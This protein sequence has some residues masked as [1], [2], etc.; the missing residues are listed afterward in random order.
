MNREEEIQKIGRL[1]QKKLDRLKE[2]D[3]LLDN[4]WHQMGLFDNRIEVNKKEHDLEGDE[5]LV[6][7]FRTSMYSKEEGERRQNELQ[8]LTDQAQDLGLGYDD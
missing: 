3:V 4:S 2:L 5:Q 8:K 1:I 6:F 7:V